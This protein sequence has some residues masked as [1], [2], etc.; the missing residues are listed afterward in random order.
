APHL[1]HGND[2]DL[3]VADATGAGRRHDLLGDGHCVAV[4]T[5]NLDPDLGHELHGELLA[6]IGLGVAALATEAARL[7]DGE[8][9]DTRVLENVFDVVELGRLDVGDHHLHGL[10]RALPRATTCG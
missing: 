10:V 5:Q 2:G 8:P 3:A 7:A 6:A 4:V 1:L 9:A